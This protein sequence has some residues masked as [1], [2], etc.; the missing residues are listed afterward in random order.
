MNYII[1]SIFDLNRLVI[2]R[3]EDLSNELLYDI[4]DYLDSCYTY[5]TLCHL[6]T[7]FNRLI[8]HSSLPLRLNFS[9]LSKATVQHRC[10]HILVPNVHRIVSLCLSHH[11]LIDY[12]FTS[13][14]LDSSFIRL[15]SFT[16]KNAK[17]DNLIRI[18]STLTFLPHLYSLTITSIEHIVSPNVVYSLIMLLPVLKYCKLSFDFWNRHVELSLS[19][20]EY[21]PIESLTLD[22]T[23]NLDELV[24]LL[25]YTP[26]LTRL[27]C[28][29]STLNSSLS[30]TSVL[31]TNL[32]NLCIKLEDTSFDEFEWFTSNCSHQLRVLRISTERDIEFLN[33][34]RWQRLISARIPHLRKF[35]FQFQTIVYDSSYDYEQYQIL[36]EK[37][38]SSFWIDRQWFFTHQSYKSKNLTSWIRFHSTQ[39]YRYSS[40]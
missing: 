23:C 24:E 7:R 28:K 2:T 32:T 13:F 10:N 31:L 29:V 18:L 33:A 36:M 21:S 4:F 15:E 40:R 22:A 19:D 8:T 37:F 30:Q 35:H 9:L 20:G 26:Q 38:N 11:L 3:F 12:F 16:L 17:S 1:I 14:F 25:N 27:L 6:N 39:P 5:E 34:N